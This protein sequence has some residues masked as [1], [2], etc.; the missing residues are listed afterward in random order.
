[1]AGN[2]T[3]LARAVS[4]REQQ[5]LKDE[6]HKDGSTGCLAD[7]GDCRVKMDR[8]SGL[9]GYGVVLV[10]AASARREMIATSWFAIPAGCL[11][12][13][14]A[15]TLNLYLAGRTTPEQE[16]LIKTDGAISKFGN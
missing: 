4:Q 5:Q 9:A 14:G 2:Y 8:N 12:Q 13:F 16:W 7:S 10:T 3:L 15:D 11:C 6:N 1:V